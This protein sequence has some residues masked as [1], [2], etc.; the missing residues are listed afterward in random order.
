MNFQFVDGGTFDK[1]E[2]GTSNF[3]F[4]SDNHALAS[5]PEPGTFALLGAGSCALGFSAQAPRARRPGVI[6][7]A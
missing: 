3:A 6:A 4:E 7:S 2:F 5:V 1:I